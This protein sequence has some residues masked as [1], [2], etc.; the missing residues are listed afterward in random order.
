MGGQERGQWESSKE[1]QA[2]LG[3]A[4]KAKQSPKSQQIDHSRLTQLGEKEKPPQLCS[5]PLVGG[6]HGRGGGSKKGSFEAEA[7]E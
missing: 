7:N 6:V 1:D 4:R 2:A 3:L 5:P